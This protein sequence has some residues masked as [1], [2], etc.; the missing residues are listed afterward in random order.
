MSPAHETFEELAPAYALGALDEEETARFEAHL[1]RGCAACTHALADYGEALARVAAGLRTPP[2]VGV[3]ER[4]LARVGRRPAGRVRR[5][6]TVVAWAASVALAAGLSSWLTSNALRS[7]YEP[8]IAQMTSA[9]KQ[10]HTRGTEQQEALDR[11]RQQLAEQE[12]ALALARA[13][14]VEKGRPLALL[15]DPATR[16][17]PLVGLTPSPRALGWM[18]WNPAAGG[19]FVAVDLPPAPADK[20]YELWT[21]TAGKPAPAGV[22]AVDPAG[23][24][25]LPVAPLPEG[26]AVD[27][28][29]V[30]LEP[31]GGVPAPTGEMF[32]VSKA[33]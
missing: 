12:K 22:F 14:A 30:T 11:L 10:L 6:V 27:L 25:S 9:T 20:A 33:T 18:V 7:T 16:V 26:V 28:F 32:L 13:E 2:P 21:I 4:V 19:V 29:A 31:A 23:K 24:A 5:L 8:V 15:R 17:I 1:R 3:R